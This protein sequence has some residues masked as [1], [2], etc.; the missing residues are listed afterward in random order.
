MDKAS[1]F[2]ILRKTKYQIASIFSVYLYVFLIL[3]YQYSMDNYNEIL[4]SLQKVD[5]QVEKIAA[6]VETGM[7]INGFPKFSFSQNDFVVDAIVWFK[8]PKEALP[9]DV[10]KSFSFKNFLFTRGNRVYQSE[11]MIKLIGSDV[12]VSFSMQFSIVAYLKNKHF[13]ISDHRLTIF[14][15]NKEVSSREMCFVSNEDNL[16][17]S[18]DI[19]VEDWLPMKKYVSCGYVSSVINDKN[20]YMRIDYPC[21]AYSIDFVS[22]GARNLFTLYFPIFV[23]F[24]IVLLC[25]T[26]SVFETARMGIIASALPILVLFRM[27]IDSASPIVGYM[28]HVD[29]TFYSL[30]LLSLQILFIEMYIVLESKQVQKMELE[31]DKQRVAVKLERVNIMNLYVVMFLLMFLMTYNYLR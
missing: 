6:K 2:R 3:L 30:V 10:I 25:L 12:F 5:P 27:V 29:F 14:L 8:Y 23:V 31:V 19:F 20:D 16:M 11:P 22:L 4:P 21:V 9:L 7:F 13:P 1:V 28:T 15:E 24:L 18:D 17:L 26:M